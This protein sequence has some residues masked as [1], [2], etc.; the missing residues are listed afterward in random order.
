MTDL[1]NLNLEELVLELKK[2]GGM[3]D[4]M[5]RSKD[6]EAIKSAFYKLLGRLKA[7]AEASG[8]D[9]AGFVPVEE[10]FKAVY[11]DYKKERAEYNREQ[12][13]VRKEN[14][15]SKQALLDELKSLVD[16]LD[17]IQSAFPVLRDIQAR[18][19]SVGQVPVTEFRNINDTYQHYVEMFYDKVHIDHDLRDLDFKKNLEAK[20]SLIAQAEELAASDDVVGSFNALQKLHEQWKEL[21]PVAKDL[22]DSIWE[23]F[24]TASGVINR[25]YQDYFEN[26]KNTFAANLKA[27][28][29]L[30]SEVEAIADKQ[31]IKDPAEWNSLSKAI[32]EI[33]VRWRGIGYATRKDNQK[34]Y[35]RFRAAC[36]KFFNRKREY[37]QAVKNGLDENIAKR[38]AIIAQAESLKTSQD[39]KKTTDQFISLQKQWK[40]LGTIP[41][42]KQEVLWK[43]FRAACDEFFA[44]RDANAKSDNSF[45]SNLKAKRALIE[46]IKSY[47][48]VEGVSDEQAQADFVRRFREIGFVPFKEKDAVSA[49]FNEALKAKFPPVLTRGELV[50]KYN[51]LQQ[52]IDTYE[53]NIGFF[54]NS[55][56]SEPLVRQMRERIDKAKAELKEIEE[57]IK[58]LK[59]A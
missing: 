53:N 21:G 44:S 22:R 9:M 3:D 23:R 41:R 54:A 59:Q 48:P 15:A 33:Q 32:E 47:Q 4:R 35:D 43:R 8:A 50:R 46:E 39:W 1:E 13:N 24:K 49:E 42:K 55:S 6:V 45:Y 28:E 31:D 16:N 40:E 20:E 27:K 36:D 51:A 25:R 58:S 38:E 52:N 10:S 11:S 37:F 30:C 2:I 34:V 7:E 14:L 26:I 29:G 57:Q 5:E 19:K 17:D 56:N 12:E 18:W